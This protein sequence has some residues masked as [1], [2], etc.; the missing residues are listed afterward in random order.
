MVSSPIEEPRLGFDGRVAVLMYH[1][2]SSTATERFRQYAIP[3]SLF[4]E[5]LAYLAE[6]GF[7]TLTVSDYAAL[8]RSH[9]APAE[10]TVV[11]TFDDAFRDFGTEALGPLQQHGFAATLYVPTAY[12]GAT[13]TWLAAEGEQGRH[14]LDWS[15]LAEVAR[16]G[17]ECG[18]H[19]HRHPQLDRIKPPAVHAEIRQSKLILEERLQRPVLSFAYPFGYRTNRVR[20]A[21]RIAGYDSCCAVRDLVSRP[22]DDLF[23][24]PRLTVTP[25][26]TTDRLAELLM[27]PRGLLDDMTSTMRAWVSRGL[28]QVGLKKRL[29]D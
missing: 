14:L 20:D 27:A 4:R 1:S 5:H 2:I 24:I 9:Q 25:D 26:T 3:P 6:R 29:T 10:R 11:L 19:S 15:E 7:T 23:D 12:V 28:R 18:G 13:S 16:A 8:R 22:S 17:V 21:V